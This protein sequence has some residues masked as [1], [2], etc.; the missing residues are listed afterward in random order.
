[1]FSGGRCT[2]RIVGW[3]GTGLLLLL[4]LRLRFLLS[5]VGARFLSCRSLLCRSLLLGRTLTCGSPFLLLLGRHRCAGRSQQGKQICG[6][7]GRLRGAEQAGMSAGCSVPLTSLLLCPYLIRTPWCVRSPGQLQSWV[8]ANPSV[9]RACLPVCLGESFFSAAAASVALLF[10][11][12]NLRRNLCHVGSAPLPVPWQPVWS[13]A[14]LRSGE[15]RQWTLPLTP[16]DVSPSPGSP[17]HFREQESASD[18]AVESTFRER[19]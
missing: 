16:V 12:R 7:S 1:M 10:L 18:T 15:Q 14:P 4:R 11:P 9:L 6:R 5:G 3:V 13:L 19:Q 17:L 8:R 2:D